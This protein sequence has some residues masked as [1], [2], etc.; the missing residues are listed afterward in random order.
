MASSA[1][2]SQDDAVQFVRLAIEMT[3]CEKTIRAAIAEV[4]SRFS[5]SENAFFVLML[6]RENLDQP[7]SQA[8]LAKTIGCS[9]GQLS[10]LVEQLRQQGCIEARRDPNDRRR[11][12]WWLTS[13]GRQ[14]LQQVLALFQQTH[15]PGP[16]SVQ[17]NAVLDQLRQLSQM[18][19]PSVPPASSPPATSRTRSQAA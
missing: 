19:N 11:Q 5:L 15:L 16:I 10:H 17:P 6:C 7:L 9:A 12:F 2:P 8:E 1:P 18:F 14:I 4:V 13:E 3:A